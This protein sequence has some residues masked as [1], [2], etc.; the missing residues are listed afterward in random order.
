MS[1]IEVGRPPRRLNDSRPTDAP[2]GSRAALSNR[3]DQ[4]DAPKAH[5]PTALEWLLRVQSDQAS[6]E[7]WAALSDWLEQSAD[8][9]R[10]YEVAERLSAE[11]D[12]DRAAILAALDAP[13]NR[14]SN[15]S[16]L[17]GAAAPGGRFGRHWPRLASP[18]WRLSARPHGVLLKGKC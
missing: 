8:H 10:A 18:P 15:S 3:T 7:D 9:L 2:R 14:S 12:E 13:R 4:S 6:A 5:L 16:P 1:A 11:I 17:C